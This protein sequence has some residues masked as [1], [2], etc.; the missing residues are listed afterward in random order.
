MNPC[1]VIQ[2]QAKDMNLTWLTSCGGGA[3][4]IRFQGAKKLPSKGQGMNALVVSTVQVVIKQKKHA[5][6][7]AKHDSG[8]EEDPDKFNF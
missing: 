4:H 3:G 6:A 1:K 5:K 7:T 2:A 8:L